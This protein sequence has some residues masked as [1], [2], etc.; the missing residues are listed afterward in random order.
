VPVTKELIE[1]ADVI[2]AMEDKNVY[3]LLKVLQ[4][5]LNSSEFVDFGIA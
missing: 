5:C 4:P 1:W 3:F 2:F